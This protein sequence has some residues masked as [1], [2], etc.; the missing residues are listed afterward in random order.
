[1][2]LSPILSPDGDPLWSAGGRH[3]YKVEEH[4][5]FVCSLEWVG[6]GRKSQPAMVI[7]PATN[8][9]VTGEGAGMCVI[10]RRAIAEFM[11]FTPDGKATGGPSE[12]CL[13]EAREALPILGKDRNDIA[14]VHAL[15]DVVVKFAEG[16]V[17]MP[18]TPT[19][20]QKD[21]DNEPMWTVEAKNKA[22]G[23]LIHEG[24]V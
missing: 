24:E 11:G 14:A 3:A 18:V 22:S 20:V 2:K 15:A 16:L 10:S 19:H 12:H 9:L 7:W 23:E 21:L 17:H 1:M 5:G 13:R 8:V 4:K 6:N